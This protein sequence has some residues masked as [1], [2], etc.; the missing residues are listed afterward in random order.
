M[1]LSG[2]A[3]LVL[4]LLDRMRSFSLMLWLNQVSPI[5]YVCLGGVVPKDRTL[6]LLY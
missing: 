5:L 4:L 2:E 6:R 3:A 1:H